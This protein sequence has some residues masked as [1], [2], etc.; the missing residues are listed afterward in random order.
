MSAIILRVGQI[1]TP[2][3]EH[4]WRMDPWE[5]VQMDPNGVVW[6]KWAVKAK[7][8]RF[9]CT[10]KDMFQMIREAGATCQTK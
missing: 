1:W 6:Y 3:K 8:K 5:I 2:S 4:T 7:R 10:T 9:D